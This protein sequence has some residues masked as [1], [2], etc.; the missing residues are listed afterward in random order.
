[1]R[2]NIIA[3]YDYSSLQVALASVCK[4]GASLLWNVGQSPTEIHKGNK[5]RIFNILK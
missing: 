5:K 2:V 1:M 4:G 3:D